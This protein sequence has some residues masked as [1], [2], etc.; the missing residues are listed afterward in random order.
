MK[1]IWSRKIPTLLGLI[2]ITIGT[3]I[4]TYLV[5]GE[6]VFRI[7][8]GPG[9]TPKNVEITNISDSSFTVTYLTDDKVLGTIL[10]G[11]SP[12]TLE[13]VVLDDRDQL[14]QSVSKYTA[15][16]ITVN[17]LEPETK[18]YFSINSGDENFKN[19]GIPFEINTGTT[20]N[21]EPT[22][23]IPVSGKAILPDGSPPAEGLAFALL[24]GSQKLSAIVKSDGNYTIPLNTL[25]TEDLNDYLKIE[26]DDVLTISVYSADMSS[27]IDVN[28]SQ[29][30]PVPVIT[31]S[32]N[33]DF[34][35]ESTP[36]TKK[37]SNSKPSFPDFSSASVKVT[38]IPTPIPTIISITPKP[39]MPT[40]TPIP[41]KL[42]EIES[43]S[44]NNPTIEPTPIPSLPP[45]G[46]SS[47]II[48]TLVSASAGLIGL[49]LFLL[50]RG[51]KPL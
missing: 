48:S 1:N 37:T 33:Y 17:N 44:V 14:T 13:N 19:D 28:L 4:T 49:T 11:S 5:K 15:H 7:N 31:L 24:N 42:P 39:T 35:S 18:Y 3:I 47:V 40:K 21:S 30:S 20:I 51:Q 12:S 26:K 46:N 45:T 29:I 25:R 38:N 16:S 41:T 22:D 9:Q 27:D 32:K 8:A 23:Q 34:T 2:T 36:T 50:T 6:T 43:I 10:Y